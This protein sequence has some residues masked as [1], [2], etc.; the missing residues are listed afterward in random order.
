[1]KK[2]IP[3]CSLLL[4]KAVFLSSSVHAQENVPKTENFVKVGHEF[5]K[6]L[7]PELNGKG[8][9]VTVETSLGYDDTK[10]VPKYF[11]LD[12]GTAPK[13]VIIECCY[14]GYF[15][16]VVP[17]PFPWSQE[18]TSPPAPSTSQSRQSIEK[19]E[20][21]WDAQGRVLPKQ[22]LSTAFI[23]DDS[24]HLVTFSA[25]G[26]AVGNRDA[27]KKL[28]ALISSHPEITYQEVVA[29]LK[30]VG[31]KYGPN[32]KERFIS[33]LPVTQLERF[34]GKVEIVSVSFSPLDSNRDN[35]EYWP[36]WRVELLAT[37]TDGTKRKYKLSFERFKG[38]LQRLDLERPETSKN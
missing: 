14:G 21:N 25:A 2:T 27:D 22:Y 12:V 8:Y 17:S 9:A 13:F 32:D 6:A 10:S 30:Q 15:G 16:G 36:D 11:M 37:Q 3:L 31:I 29:A 35:I 5:L 28:I 24:G 4:L 34:L 18:T 7:Y 1:M 23:F 26:P 33:D 19:R 38:D 20:K